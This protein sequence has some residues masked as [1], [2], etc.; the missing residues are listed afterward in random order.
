[1][2]GIYKIEN[3]VNGKVYIGESMDIKRRWEEHKLDLNNCCHHSYK[4]QL[5][6]GKYSYDKFTFEVVEEITYNFKCSIIK[7][8]LF[9]LED[10]YIKQYN[11]LNEGY[12]I[13]DTLNKIL[14]GEKGVFQDNKIDKTHINMLLYT[15]NNIEKNN[16]IYIQSDKTKKKEDKKKENKKP[17]SYSE[18]VKTII[19]PDCDIKYFKELMCRE[20]LFFEKHGSYYIYKK[21]INKYFIKGKERKNKDGFKYYTIMMTEQGKDFVLNLIKGEINNK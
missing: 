5:D 10:K 4:L 17:I 13:E 2:I 6:W 12:N 19:S 1:M 11:S 8:I 20:N 15:K 3:I 9:V 16:G 7:L 21:Y 14:N 18:F